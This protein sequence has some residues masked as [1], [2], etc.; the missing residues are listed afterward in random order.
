MAV[1]IRP[2]SEK[3]KNNGGEECI[4]CVGQNAV[5]I[6]KK[7]LPKAVLRSQQE[8]TNDYCFDHVFGPESTQQE[9]YDRAAAEHIPSVLQG[10]VYYINI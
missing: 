1:R 8:Q 3:E 6:R 5:E 9:V 10:Y 4:E 2:L 7:A